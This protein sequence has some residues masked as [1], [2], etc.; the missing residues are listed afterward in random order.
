MICDLNC[1]TWITLTNWIQRFQFAV[2][3]SVM[4]GQNQHFCN[5]D[6]FAIKISTTSPSM[7]CKPLSDHHNGGFKIKRVIFT[8][9]AP[10]TRSYC[11]KKKTNLLLL[12]FNYLWRCVMWCAV[13]LHRKSESPSNVWE[14][15]DFCQMCDELAKSVSRWWLVWLWS[16]L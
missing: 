11:L 6:F 4:C 15:Q 1:L 7:V 16:R 2:S 10:F 3:E 13:D 12:M 5:I 9:P 14:N 8:T